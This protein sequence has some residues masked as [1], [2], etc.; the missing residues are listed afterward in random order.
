M[1][2][3]V[4]KS[5]NKITLIP[6]CYLCGTKPRIR[7]R[8]LFLCGVG[9]RLVQ[10]PPGRAQRDLLVPLRRRHGQVYLSI[11]LSINIYTYI[12][13]YIHTYLFVCLSVIT[14]LLSIYLSIC[15]ILGEQPPDTWD[16]FPLFQILNDYLRTD[17]K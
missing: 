9:L 1:E 12:Y 13:V 17:G 2:Y 11:Y 4:N 5:S 7:L 14:I 15:R 8:Q 6:S 3:A 16:S 10:R